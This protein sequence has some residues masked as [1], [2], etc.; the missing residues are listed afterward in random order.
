MEKSSDFFKKLQSS[1]VTEMENCSIVMVCSKNC[2]NALYVET[3]R[4]VFL[5]GK[6]LVFEGDEEWGKYYISRQC[7]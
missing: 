5:Q 6:F 1:M 4:N 7:A 3:A 2:S